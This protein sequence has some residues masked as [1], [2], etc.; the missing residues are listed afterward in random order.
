MYRQLGPAVVVTAEALRADVEA[1]RL[2]ARVVL[3]PEPERG[4]F[5]SVQVGVAA[6]QPACDLLFLT[7]VDCVLPDAAVP[8]LLLAAAATGPA[9][10]AWVPTCAGRRGHPLLLDRRAYR[11]LLAH[12][13]A[14]VLSAVVA[15]LRVVDVPVPEPRILLNINTPDDYSRLEAW[16]LR[17]RYEG[18]PEH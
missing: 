3:N 4:M 2:P 9:G 14:A 12:P 5:S 15:S 17:E 1:L 10:T 11:G 13:A 6:V 16:G 7:P 18:S 8:R